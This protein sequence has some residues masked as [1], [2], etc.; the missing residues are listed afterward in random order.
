[1]LNFPSLLAYINCGRS[2]DEHG[3]GKAIVRQLKYIFN[4]MTVDFG[5]YNCDN[6]K[7]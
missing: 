7:S 1:M 5:R 6:K 4:F 2:V 3:T